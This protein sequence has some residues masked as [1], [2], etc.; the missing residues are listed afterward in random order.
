MVDDVQRER[1][2]VEPCT[3]CAGGSGSAR[4][5][6]AEERAYGDRLLSDHAP[7]EA[8]I[9]AGVPRVPEAML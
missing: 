1:L 4:A 8:T 5:W 7:V 9:R 3:R 6:A 2:G